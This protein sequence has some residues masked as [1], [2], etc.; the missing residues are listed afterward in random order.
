MT[1]DTHG[2]WRRWH[3][4][5]LLMTLAGIALIVQASMPARPPVE[6]WVS[7]GTE[8]LT[9]KIGLSGRIAP[10][11]TFVVNAPFEGNVQAVLVEHGQQVQ[12]GQTLLTMD[13]ASI[14]MQLRDALSAQLKAQ[15]ITQELTD[16]EQGAQVVRA[17]RSLRTAEMS[18]NNLKRRLRDSQLLLERGIIAR[19]ELDDLKQQLQLQELEREAAQNELQQALDQG[20]GEHRRIAHMELTNATVKYDG[21]RALLEGQNIVAPFTGVVVPVSA[22]QTPGT[23]QTATLQAGIRLN[24]GQAL[25]GVADIEQLKIVASVSEL[26]INQLHPGQEVEIEGDGFEGERLSGTVQIVSNLAEPGDEEN[27]SAKFSITLSLPKLTDEQLR[28]VRLGM[29][30]RL[31]IITYRNEQAMVIPPEAIRHEGLNKVVDYR[32]TL[33]RQI[34]QKTI[35]IGRSTLNGVEVFGLSPGFVRLGRSDLL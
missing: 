33:D 10:Q 12:K 26:Y 15:R 4:V 23:F 32:E 18:L 30:A 25:F 17:R 1:T 2:R 9:Y 13:S 22:S 34:Q 28:H 35:A 27:A 21:L 19:N 11:R 24:Q 6:N 16:W 20:T 29:S 5:A 7:V 3:T 31:S 8:P 14:E